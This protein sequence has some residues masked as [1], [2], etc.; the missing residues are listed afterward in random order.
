MR[1]T[2]LIFSAAALLFGGCAPMD[3]AMNPIDKYQQALA[4][5][6]AEFSPGS[7]QEK[8]AIARFEKFFGNLTEQNARELTRETY[9]DPV[10]FYDTLKVVKNREE[11]EEYFVET[12]RNTES[13]KARIVDVARSGRDYYVRW[14]MEI[15]LKKFRRGETLRSVGMT[16]LRF[17][18][19]GKI[20]MHHDYWD[21]TSGFFEHVPALG[22]VLRWI[23][24]KF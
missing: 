1:K 7:A 11:L 21:S 12:A 24:Q 22:G 3:K 5:P 19:E 18:P 17:S 10:F 16:H 14:E 23:K 4:L 6:A 15:R 20:Q 9:T 8:A 2:L 13:V